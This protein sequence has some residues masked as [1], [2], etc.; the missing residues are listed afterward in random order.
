[1]NILC[2]LIGYELKNVSWT[3]HICNY[4]LLKI[5]I[6]FDDNSAILKVIQDKLSVVIDQEEDLNSVA[7]LNR[8]QSIAISIIIGTIERNDSAIVFVDGPRGTGKTYL[9]RA[10]LASLSMIIELQ[11]GPA[12]WV[13]PKLLQAWIIKTW[14]CPVNLVDPGSRTLLK[15]G[16]FDHP[17]SIQPE[18]KPVRPVM[19]SLTSWTNSPSRTIPWTHSV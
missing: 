6:D 14:V 11:I 19:P 18:D 12:W 16:Q 3:Q 15:I 13:C 2:G 5:T 9:Y 8:D 1:M 7:T 17:G 4:D 10:L